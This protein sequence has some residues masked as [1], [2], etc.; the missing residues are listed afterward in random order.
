M[1]DVFK[2]KRAQPSKNVAAVVSD[3]ILAGLTE[4]GLRDSSKIVPGFL[5]GTLVREAFCYG[6]REFADDSTGVFGEVGD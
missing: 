5:E 3:I 4:F 6:C 1:H 2:H